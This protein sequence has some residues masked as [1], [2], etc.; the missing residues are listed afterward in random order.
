M[1]YANGTYVLQYTAVTSVGTFTDNVTVT[2]DPTATDPG[3][4]GGG[5]VIGT[6]PSNVSV[7]TA[8]V[9]T[10]STS[11]NVPAPAGVVNGHFQICIVQLDIATDSFTT[12][13]AGWSL[14]DEQNV[15][16]TTAPSKAVI[17]YNTNGDANTLFLTKSGSGGFHAVRMAWKD[18][19]ALGQH[20]SRGSSS[21]TT[22]Y[23]PT[24]TP[25]VNKALVVTVLG[26]DRET[27]GV[28]PVTVPTGWTER[29]NSGQAINSP[30][31]EWIAVA[32]LQV[33]NKAATGANAPTGTGVGTS[34]FTLTNADNCSMFAFVL[35]AAATSGVGIGGAVN[36][37]AQPQLRINYNLPSIPPGGLLLTALTQ[38]RV[39][40]IV[41]GGVNLYADSSL[42][43]GASLFPR[44]A[45]IIYPTLTISIAQQQSFAALLLQVV[46]MLR[47]GALPYRRPVLRTEYVYPPPDHP[48]RLIAQRILDGEIVEWE[49]PVSEDFE[50][51]DQLSG[52]CVMHGSFSPEQISVQELG[53]DGYAYWLHVE[54]NQQIRA[55]A[56]MLPPQFEEST[57]TFSAEGVAAV[58]HYS[59]FDN[60]FS[61]IQVDPLS[62]VRTLWNYVQAQPQSD[63][64]V[65]VSNNSS[66]VRLGEP[67]HTETTVTNNDDGTT[68][69][70]IRE[71][72]DKP[73]ELN[74]WDAKNIGEEIDTLS[75]STPFDYVERH[76][77]NA[78]KTDVLHFIDLGY[79]RLGVARPNLLFNEENILE[80][81]P[82]Q[83][84][85]D[86]YASAVLVIGAGDGADTI[87]AYRAEAFED[88]I[89]KEVV[90]TDKSITSQQLADSRA[91]QEI[92]F[93]RG[94]AFEIG[95][96]VINA[97][98]SNAPIGSYAIGDDIQVQVEIS[99]LMEL[100]TSWYRITSINNKP[101]SDKVRLGLA[102][103]TTLLDTSDIWIEPDDYVPIPPPPPIG[104]VAWNGNVHLAIVATLAVTPPVPVPTG[105]VFL[106]V[107]ATLTA[108]GVGYGGSF[109]F[110][111]N[112]FA[113]GNLTING[114]MGVLVA[115]IS[116]PATAVLMPSG[117]ATG[118]GFGTI[119]L[120]APTSLVVASQ[121]PTGAVTLNATPTLSALATGVF[122]NN[123]V[124]LNVSAG[125]TAGAFLKEAGAVSLSATVV[126]TSAGTISS[127]STVTQLGKTTDGATSSSS[128][129]NK[130][131]VS[132]V[133]ASVSGTVTAGH[134]RLWIDTGTASVEMV[135]Y[136]DSGGSP[137]SLLGLSDTVT[138]SN[139][140]EAQKDFTFSGVQQAA[141]TAGTDYWIGFTWPDPGTNNISWS[142]DSTA[143]Q[144]QQN[145]LHAATTFGTP[146]T[147][148]SGPI[149]AYVDVTSTSGGGG[150][151]G[152]LTGPGSSPALVTADSLTTATTAAFNVASN[153]VLVVIVG[154]DR[155]NRNSVYVGETWTITNSGTALTWSK[156]I[157]RSDVDISADYAGAAIYTAP[158]SSAR[159]GMTVTAS[160]ST[161]SGYANS[162]VLA[163]YVIPGADLASPVGTTNGGF[164]TSN[165]FTN[166]GVTTSRSGSLVFF[167]GIN[168]TALGT[169]SS[170]DLTYAGHAGAISGA[171]DYITGWKT[172]GSS[173]ASVTANIDGAGTSAV[174]WTWV[175]AE[176]HSA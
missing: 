172:G 42:V 138:V 110:V 166:G 43:V 159:T 142:R 170:S 82:V 46:P 77:W 25:A 53:L 11:V 156:A 116:L 106:T 176:I 45:F 19:S 7:G 111:N 90:I 86:T 89:R 13:P 50:Y 2:V 143:S 165:A 57:F 121:T 10:G 66:P 117:I 1:A 168:F 73:Y 14:L 122:S 97:Y 72:P 6:Y 15:P 71:I 150:G 83:E 174:K 65:V 58:P 123:A 31:F 74:W 41:Q 76:A 51:T 128:S 125:L 112:L 62:V 135:V 69:T 3:T 149:D 4:G 44:G 127:G 94:R 109:A 101:S 120:I 75:G 173:G 102:R 153:S 26:S 68:T 36:L 124:A 27:A 162:V 104:A 21:T 144:A 84:P 79:P 81:V 67:A 64:G 105:R 126:L 91:A 151:G 8:A 22:P 146:G 136:S 78:T 155:G 38:L 54:I 158:V 61:Q 134:S 137:G 37:A 48:F 28:G 107:T 98:H 23:S 164:S 154:C 5:G 87:R 139:T 133:T 9:S 52:P 171:I 129:A 132:K 18:W 119:T 169:P 167:G 131:V 99:W 60:V 113:T 17:L 12:L 63:F 145:A 147:A 80:I 152:T 85:E 130:T 49:L 95:E 33:D 115:A 108:N 93:R 59:Y 96:L 140:T 103:S 163:V 39:Q 16:S 34:N 55:S 30:N 88:R 148:L 118:A 29:Y 141:I 47:T 32:E 157:Q 175:A 160:V 92:A 20:S 114:P 70:T 161:T 56:I 100:H 24:V 35:E 40:T